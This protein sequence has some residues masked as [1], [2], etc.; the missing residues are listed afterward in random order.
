MKQ[1]Q[2]HRT[3]SD[4]RTPRVGTYEM[5]MAYI[6]RLPNDHRSIH[7]LMKELALRLGEACALMISDLDIPNR[8]ILIGRT[9]STGGLYPK[10]RKARWLPLSDMALEAAIVA[11]SG[12][13]AEQLLFINPV[14]GEGYKPSFLRRLYN[15]YG[16]SHHLDLH[17]LFRLTTISD[18]ARSNQ[19]SAFAIKELARYSDVHAIQRYYRITIEDLRRL[20]NRR[21]LNKS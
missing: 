18:W 20:V 10:V 9:F 19:S 11:S 17:E 5:Q 2:K 14:T 1:T 12:R 4:R 8:M 16:F 3:L 6:Q 15:K 21:I 13:S 7:I